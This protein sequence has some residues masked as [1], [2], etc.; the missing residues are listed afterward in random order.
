MMYTL[1]MCRASN[2][3]A[4]WLERVYIICSSTRNLCCISGA[5]LREIIIQQAHECVAPSKVGT[6]RGIRG[7]DRE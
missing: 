3:Q 5:Y 1:S 7:G 6:A 2:L 4:R